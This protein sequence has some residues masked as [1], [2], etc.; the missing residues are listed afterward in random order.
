[1][2]VFFTDGAFTPK[3]EPTDRR[4]E[5]A[6]RIRQLRM[7]LW[8]DPGDSSELEGMIEAAEAE[9]RELGRGGR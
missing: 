4:E 5:L 3:R 8:A 9:L 7:H 6:L 1:M 2:T